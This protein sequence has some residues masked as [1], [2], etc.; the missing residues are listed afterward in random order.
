MFHISAIIPVV[1]I[2]YFKGI[3]ISKQ[4][5]IGI[6]LVFIGGI[7]IVYNSNEVDR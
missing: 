6:I 1:I 4:E 5:K 7:T 3:V 2:S